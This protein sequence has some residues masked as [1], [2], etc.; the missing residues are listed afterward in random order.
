MISA[1]T[2][3]LSAVVGAVALI[4]T[5]ALASKPN[6]KRVSGPES[7]SSRTQPAYESNAIYGWEGQY[8]GWDPDPNIRTQLMRDQNLK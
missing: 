8:R 6:K 3:L 5:P 1:K 7:H 4:V 2:K